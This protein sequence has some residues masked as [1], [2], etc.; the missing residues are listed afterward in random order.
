VADS[1]T[2]H[3]RIV[4][5][6]DGSQA[7]AEAL[8]WAAAEAARHEAQLEAVIAWRPAGG[9]GPPAGSPPPSART[10]E[11]REEDAETVLDGALRGIGRE[12]GGLDVQ[13]RVMRGTPHRVLVEAADGASMLVIG[14]RPGKLAGKKP[15]STGQHVVREAH[16]PVV[17][18]PPAVVRGAG[19]S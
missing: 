16:C 7:A 19:A 17:V 18:V 4:V 5:G 12:D 15:W 1:A 8:R 9:L 3:Q 2:E 6:V 10:V 11:E 14:G 13:R